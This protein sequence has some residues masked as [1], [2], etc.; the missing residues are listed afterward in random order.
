M[1]S[2]AP[3]FNRC[4]IFETSEISW[5]GF[6]RLNPPD[7]ITRRAWTVYFYTKTRPNEDEIPLRNTEYVEPPMPQHIAAGYTLRDDDVKILQEGY[8]RRDD[9]IRMLYALRREFD[10]KYSHLWNE[11][12]YY[13]NKFNEL[14]NK[15]G[16]EE[17]GV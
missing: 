6:D 5:H 4:L 10:K 7:G 17:G 11:Y 14:K 13:L 15:I 9:R 12:E 2:I 1:K 3:V 16:H 8:V